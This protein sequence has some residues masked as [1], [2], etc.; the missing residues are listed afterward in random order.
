[1]EVNSK[2]FQKDD[3]F[4]FLHIPK[5]AGT[6]L[7]NIVENNFD[8]K[9]IYLERLWPR[10]FE[11]LPE[12]LANFKLIRG[13]FGYWIYKLLPKAPITLTILRDPIE[14][15]LSLH[16][17][18]LRAFNAR[19]KE[20]LVTHKDQSLEEIFDI[21]RLRLI[22]TNHQIR[23]L[24]LDMDVN[25]LINAIKDKGKLT[26][27]IRRLYGPKLITKKQEELLKIAKE[28][29]SQFA[30]FGIAEKFEESMFLLYF[31]FGWFPIRIMPKLNIASNRKKIDYLPNE[32]AAKLKELTRFDTQLYQYALE[33]FDKR[34]QKMQEILHDRYYES[35]YSDMSFS[36]M[37]YDM[38]EKHYFDRNPELK[39]QS[40]SEINYSFDQKMIG[41]GWHEREK[42]HN[43][44]VLR[45]TGPETNSQIFFLLDNMYDLKIQIFI[46]NKISA[47]VLDSLKLE[48]NNTPME[49]MQTKKNTL[50]GKKEKIF[51]ATILKSLISEK[52]KF[53]QFS[54]KVNRTAQSKIM[55]IIPR[56]SRKLG[57]AFN[58]IKIIPIK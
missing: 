18:Q 45:W 27:E 50:I 52:N 15:T 43:G 41:S 32:T 37:M 16:D 55:G 3:V 46:V 25:S 13:H 36:E 58:K 5:T 31:T 22:F 47:D 42:D 56:D 20:A 24:T 7:I 23:H 49:I 28:R 57:L 54:F 8:Y 6:S 19:D 48:V 12:N 9:Q 38:L 10:L 2:N 29:L 21:P 14:Q 33:L 35:K 11:N 39:N 26:K 51:E 53:T 44:E 40:I 1:M 17:H 34:Y 4:Y 30:Y